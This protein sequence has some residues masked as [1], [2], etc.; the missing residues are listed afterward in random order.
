VLVFGEMHSEFENLFLFKVSL[1]IWHSAVSLQEVIIFL[2]QC[3]DLFP[4]IL[5]HFEIEFCKDDLPLS[6]KVEAF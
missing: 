2:L 4:S 6:Q 1:L 5:P 3:F